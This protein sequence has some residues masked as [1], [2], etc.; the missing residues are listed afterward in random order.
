[1]CQERYAKA[2]ARRVRLSV[3]AHLEEQHAAWVARGALPGHHPR[4]Y[5]VTLTIPHEREEGAAERLLD[6]AWRRL[7]R[8]AARGHWSRSCLAVREWTPGRDGRGHPHLHVVVV[9][10]WVDY[11]HV[12]ATWR[13]AAL[14]VGAGEPSGYGTDV[15]VSRGR[16]PAKTAAKYVA[17]YLAAAPS[18]YSVRDWARLAAWMQGRRLLLVSRGW[19]RADKP[20]CACCDQRFLWCARR[21]GAWLAVGGN[22]NPHRHRWLVAHDPLSGWCRM[23]LDNDNRGLEPTHAYAGGSI[24]DEQIL[25]DKLTLA[26]LE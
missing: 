11:S 1:V 18:L 20:R 13:E 4:V 8:H 10:S 22:I 12:R 7:R 2:Q 14:A 19:W 17:K 15:Q 23:Q 25:R 5:M 24:E 16:N 26:M 9:S 6:L 3:E 21:D